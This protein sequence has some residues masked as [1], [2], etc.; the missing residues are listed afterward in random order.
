MARS[1]ILEKRL[2]QLLNSYY[3]L[4]DS[5]SPREAEL[6]GT[7]SGFCEALILTRQMDAASVK[8][9]MDQAHHQYFGMDRDTRY[10]AVQGSGHIWS[11]PDWEKF[12]QPTYARRPRRS[13]RK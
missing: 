12:D 7:V 3:E 11:Q 1:E 8:K 2:R 9:I 6:K 13:D 10:Y 5:N 4:L